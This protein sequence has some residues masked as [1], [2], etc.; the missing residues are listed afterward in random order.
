MNSHRYEYLRE[1]A[2][3]RS[4]FQMYLNSSH[5]TRSKSS[6]TASIASYNPVDWTSSYLGPMSVL[7]QVFVAIWMW[8][9]RSIL[10]YNVEVCTSRHCGLGMPLHFCGPCVHHGRR[11][12]CEDRGVGIQHVFLQDGLVLLHSVRQG[13]VVVF[14]PTTY[15]RYVMN[16]LSVICENC[17]R[18]SRSLSKI[19]DSDKLL[20]F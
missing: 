4:N 2:V 20:Y 11:E 13:N 17:S 1:L 3:F 6:I 10:P 8:H 16:I 12:D 9:V 7:I 5:R 14:C 15:N 19:N 18:M